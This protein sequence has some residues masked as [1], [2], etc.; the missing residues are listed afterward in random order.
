MLKRLER[1]IKTQT[2]QSERV[3]GRRA[4]DPEDPDPDPY[5]PE[6]PDMVGDDGPDG[7]HYELSSVEEKKELQRTILLILWLLVIVYSP[8]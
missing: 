7:S 4:D 1:K 8:R 6:D 3:V 2:I 5:D